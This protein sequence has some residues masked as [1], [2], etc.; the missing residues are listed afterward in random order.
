[1]KSRRILELDATRGFAIVLMIIF[2]FSFDLSYFHF[3]DFKVNQGYW[4]WFRYVIVTL[5][6][7]VSGI[8]M[9]LATRNGIRWQ[10]YLFR[11]AQVAG[12]ALAVTVATRIVFPHLWVYF[13]VLHFIALSMLAGLLFIRIPWIALIVGVAMFLMF[14]LTSWFN[15]HWLYVWLRPML[16]LPRGTQDLAR[17]VPWFGMILIGIWLGHQN[18]K[19]HFPD[20]K[21]TRLLAWMG[22]YSL[23]IY[24]VHQI[25]LFELVNAVYQLSKW[26]Q[27]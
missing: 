21:V 1:M 19:V 26:W 14:N 18:W 24:L 8:S 3:V 20:Y 12:G 2:H 6:F 22:R 23:T 10:R 13:G 4:D 17:F 5:F 15:L 11:V 16:H 27:A 25:I 7:S 9:V